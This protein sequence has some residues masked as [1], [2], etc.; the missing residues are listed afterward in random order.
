[1]NT[2]TDGKNVARLPQDLIDLLLDEPPTIDV[3]GVLQ[4][5][6]EALMNRDPMT[7]EKQCYDS[8]HTPC[9]CTLCK[10]N[11]AIKFLKK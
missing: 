5:A 2:I 4:E 7:R 10:I 11:S 6:K 9:Q 8:G 1:M 3:I